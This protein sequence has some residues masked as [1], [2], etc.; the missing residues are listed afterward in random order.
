[1]K[2]LLL[3]SIVLVFLAFNANAKDNTLVWDPSPSLLEV[4]DPSLAI[5]YLVHYGTSTDLKNAG[6][7][8]ADQGPSPIDVGNILSLQITGL[9]DDS[10]HYFAVTAYIEDRD[11]V[12][13]NIVSS[14]PLPPTLDHTWSSSDGVQLNTENLITVEMY[15]ANTEY[16]KKTFGVVQ[17]GQVA[18][19]SLDAYFEDGTPETVTDNTMLTVYA[20]DDWENKIISSQTAMFINSGYGSHKA[21]VV[22][23]GNYNYAELVFEF[24]EKTGTYQFQKIK[25]SLETPTLKPIED[26]WLKMRDF[27]SITGAI[28]DDVWEWAPISPA[29]DSYR[30]VIATTLK[31]AVGKE[32]SS[33]YGDLIIPNNGQGEQR[34]TITKALETY[35]YFI[36]IS[37]KYGN[38]ESV[39]VI[40]ASLPGNV[41]G[42]AEGDNT[43]LFRDVKI[44]ND[45]I[46]EV[47]SLYR[48]R[49]YVLIPGG[50]SAS[51]E[52]RASIYNQSII[53]SKDYFYIR[54]RNYYGLKMSLD[55]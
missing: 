40:R 31:G 45:D 42:V 36:A 32:P 18:C 19:L 29:P 35:G 37:A 3:L 34:L 15:S 5:G 13:S 24:G 47:F 7:Q 20:R 48:T 25:A 11:S 38:E 26:Y 6:G 39:P 44:Q 10:K 14:N 52:E 1:M 30:V 8:E 2:K 55:W 33:V 53:V 43:V 41:L 22:F 28:F 50:Q 51:K 27:P 17:K 46:S 16:I 23:E 49:A 54:S 9:D 4:S 12:L 21:C